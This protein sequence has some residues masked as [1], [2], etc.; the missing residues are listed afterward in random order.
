MAIFPS[1]I[2]RFMVAQEQNPKNNMGGVSVG[3]DAAQSFRSQPQQEKVV[4]SQFPQDAEF[5]KDVQQ[6]GAGDPQQKVKQ[7]PGVGGPQQ[8]AEQPSQQQEVDDEFKTFVFKMLEDLG[9]P[10]RQL[11]E[12]GEKLI[13][14][15]HDLDTGSV[16]GFYLI[17]TYTQGHQ[18]TESR[19]KALAARM[20]L[21]FNL[22]QSLKAGG[23]NYRVDFTSRGA[24]EQMGHGTSFDQLGGGQKGGMGG[25]R[26]A[27]GIVPTLSDM[28]KFSKD[29]LFD[30]IV[31]KG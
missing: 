25:Q 1:G 13:E 18:I 5:P 14:I 24:Q 22:S 17:P 9:V 15:V 26:K 11:Q 2:R 3:D 23:M 20:G 16:R 8:E 19:A 21:K 12:N 7:Q 28:L 4:D 10:S 27:A 29:E 30:Q 6:P 31:K